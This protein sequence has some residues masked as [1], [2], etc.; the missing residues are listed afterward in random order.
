MQTWD[1]YIELTYIVILYICRRRCRCSRATSSARWRIRRASASSSGSCRASGPSRICRARSTLD[2]PVVSQHL[3]A[4]AR[5]KRR[6]RAARGH[7]GLLRAAQPARRRPAARRARVPEP[8]SV[9]EPVREP[10]DAAR[11]QARGRKADASGRDLRSLA[12]QVDPRAARLRPRSRSGT[13][14]SPASPSASS[15]CRWRWRL[16]SPP[17]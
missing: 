3:A 7:A 1:V 10:I 6:H 15:R 8:S 13:I 12:A 17:A 2:Q 4:L 5:E 16:P 9:R 14:S 11:A